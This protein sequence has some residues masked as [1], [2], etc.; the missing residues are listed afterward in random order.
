MSWPNAVDVSQW[1]GNINWSDVDVPIAIIKMSGGDVGLY[2]DSKANQNYYG[3]KAAGKAVGGY[4]FAGGGDPENEADFFI[5]CM[6]PLEKDDVLIL[7]WEIDHPDPVGWCVRFIQRCK[8]RA[9][10]T[11]IFYTNQNRVVTHNWQ[12]VVDQNVGLWVAH[13]GLSPDENMNVGAWPTYIM[14]QYTSNG[15]VSGIAGR[16]DLDA[17]FGS[18]DQFRRYGFQPFAGSLP[19]PTPEPVPPLLPVPEPA[20]ALN[21]LPVPPPAPVKD[22]AEENNGLLKQI[23][24]LLQKLADKIFGVFK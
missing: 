20:P 8:D 9:G 10:V 7:D 2:T 1:Q 6:S 21:P 4:H 19:A 3:A 13:Y 24:T 22:Y 12:A 23:L 17:W 18:V 11:P 14:H 15:S 16:V 5:A